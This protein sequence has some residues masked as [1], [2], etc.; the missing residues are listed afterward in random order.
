MYKQIYD[1]TNGHQE[2]VAELLVMNITVVND[3]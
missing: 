2:E 3:R 1:P